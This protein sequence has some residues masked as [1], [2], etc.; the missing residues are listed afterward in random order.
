MFSFSKTYNQTK[1][2]EPKLS[3]YLLI[4]CGRKELFMPFPETLAWNERQLEG[5][6]FDLSLIWFSLVW[7][8]GISIIV[9]N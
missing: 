5:L 8:Y 9:R 3:Y 6:G 7:F 4:P 2:T 1:S